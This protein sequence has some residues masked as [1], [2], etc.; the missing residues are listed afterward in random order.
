VTSVS[1][2]LPTYNCGHYIGEAIDS[3]LGQTQVPD[4]ILIIDDGSTDDTEQVV[5]RYSDPRI[6]YIKQSNAG[7]SVARNTGL[8][9]ARG[10]FVTFLD[11]DD[12]WRPTFVERMHHLLA[13]TPS[14]V[15]GFANFIRFDEQT[16]ETMRDQFSYYP[17][18]GSGHIPHERAFNTLVRWGEW[19]GF[20]VVL[21]F[22]R[23][24]LGGIRCDPALVV[25]QD[26]HFALRAFMRGAVVYTN[27]I[28]CEVRRHGTNATFDFSTMALYK[29]AALKA[30]APFVA[31]HHLA[32]YQ[33][34]LVKAH[35]DAAIHLT[36]SG[37]V[38]AGLRNYW[39][40]LRVPSS[41]MRKIKGT[42]RM[43]L[44][45]PS[46]LKSKRGSHA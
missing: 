17:V 9:A 18:H 34:R 41:P 19:P 14:A 31:G 24:R 3:I 40:A 10:E 44:T 30:L 21:M 38:R 12:R 16:G 7:V 45:M 29:L 27:E 25:C 36:R 2:I 33:D 35:I 4:Q 22:R 8:D 11:A 32:A 15:A 5:R 28:L 1:V 37:R 23:D 26:A 46:G 20:P 42:A 6:E 13:V 43:A 39:D